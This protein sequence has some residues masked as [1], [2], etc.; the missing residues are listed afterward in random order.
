VPYQDLVDPASMPDYP[1]IG[2]NTPGVVRDDFERM[3]RKRAVVEGWKPDFKWAIEEG[4]RARD[5]ALVLGGKMNVDLQALAPGFAKWKE[6][7]KREED[8]R[9]EKVKKAYEEYREGQDG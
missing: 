2:P 9:G 8:N 7:T 6:R 1:K 3:R 5:R 4:L